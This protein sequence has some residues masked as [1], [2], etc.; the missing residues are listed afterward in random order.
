MAQRVV[1][2]IGLMKS[3]TTFIQG[4][5]G[6]NRERLAA[7]GVLF[8]GPSWRRHVN[9]VTDFMGAAH[10]TPGSWESLRDEINDHAGTAVVSMEYLAMLGPRL[11][12]LLAE[13]F[14]DADVRILVGARDLGRTVPAMWQEA[15]KNRSTRTWTEYVDSIRTRGESGKRFWRQQHL[16]RIVTR[17]VEHVG[18]EQVYL[19][20]LP[21]PQA[22]RDRLWGRFCEVCGIRGESSWDE[23]PRTNESLGAASTLVVRELN[24]LTQDLSLPDYRRRVK[25]L[26]KHLMPVHGA[27]E[28]PIGFQV[29]AWLHDEADTIR[30]QVR[31]SGVH[32]LGDL[33]E[34]TP[35]DVTGVDPGTVDAAAQR[36]A[37]LAALAA[38]L[39]Q[40]HRVRAAA[41][42]D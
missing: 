27:D 1:V 38:T 3:G 10:R 7:Q 34:L 5:L 28:S 39:R 24:L 9:A 30:K 15:V 33:D 12:P 37:A 32:V 25:A 19:V 26:A 14:G 6:A 21:P 29:P 36:D 2:H 4:R 8:P 41:V 31:D 17:W 11:I 22:P 20:T 42:A 16:G 23:A 18:P 35:L 40:V 13:S